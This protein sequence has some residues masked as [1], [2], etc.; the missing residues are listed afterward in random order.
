MVVIVLDGDKTYSK[1]FF[2][3]LDGYVNSKGF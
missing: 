2:S 1:L 3:K